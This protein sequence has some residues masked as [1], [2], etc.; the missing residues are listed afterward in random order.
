MKLLSLFFI[1]SISGNVLARHCVDEIVALDVVH[2]MHNYLRSDVDDREYLEETYGKDYL[3]SEKQLDSYLEN[4]KYLE[5]SRRTA[6]RELILTGMYT[7]D[8]SY[9]SGV[10]PGANE[11]EVCVAARNKMKDVYIP[12]EIIREF[13]ERRLYYDHKAHC[14]IHLKYLGKNKK[15]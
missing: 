10:D 11:Q 7:D 13:S 8:E 15:K 6:K 5:E 4:F 9:I 1:I 14:L 12:M 3:C 2:D